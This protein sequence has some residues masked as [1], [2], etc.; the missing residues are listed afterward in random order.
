M[1]DISEKKSELDEYGVWVKKPPVD[2]Q[3]NAAPA[4]DPV[5]DASFIEQAAASDMELEQ[6]LA[7][8]DIDSLADFNIPAEDTAIMDETSVDEPNAE[9][10]VTEESE[11]TSE[12][13]SETLQTETI[14]VE[15]PEQEEE[16]SID[17]DE[18]SLDDFALDAID[19]DNGPM[20]FVQ[21]EADTPDIPAEDEIQATEFE[22]KEN[23]PSTEEVSFEDGEIDLD[24]FMSDDS[25]QSTDSTPDGEV[26]LSSF[27]DDSSAPSQDGEVD[28]SAFMDDSG[29]SPDFGNGDIDLEAFM[30]SEGFATDKQE[31]E[32]IEDADPLD[33]DLDFE[34]TD[35]E[36]Q[37]AEANGD[38]SAIDTISSFSGMDETTD[39]DDFD[40]LFDD[41]VDETPAAPEIPEVT[42]RT[43]TPVEG[44]EE[45]NLSDFGFDDNSDNQNPIL[46]DGKPEPKKQG[47][48]DYEMNVEDDDSN[49]TDSSSAVSMNQ[50]DEDDSDDFN[51]DITQDEEKAIQKEQATDL[52]SPD[53]SFDIDSI[54]DNIEDETGGK[55]S[56][57]E[58]TPETSEAKAEAE[59]VTESEPMFPESQEPD[60]GENIE[61][62]DFGIDE[63]TN[64]AESFLEETVIGDTLLEEPSIEEDSI[65]TPS[66]FEE[67]VIEEVSIG[68]GVFEE[69]P[70]DE[71][72]SP[73]ES[74]ESSSI[75]AIVE[76][77]FNGEPSVQ[78]EPNDDTVFEEPIIDDIAIDESVF[79]EPVIETSDADTS[80][81]TVE[82][83]AESEETSFEEPVIEESVIEEEI[84]DVFEEPLIEETEIEESEIDV[85]VFEENE[86]ASQENGSTEDI[87]LDDFVTESPVE[88]ESAK[89]QTVNNSEDSVSVDN[90]ENLEYN[91]EDAS[92][93][94][95]SLDD[96]MGEEGFT[97]GGPGVTGPYNEDGTLIVR[98]NASPSEPSEEEVLEEVTETIQEETSEESV[99]ETENEAVEETENFEDFKAEESPDTETMESEPMIEEETNEPDYSNISAFAD[100]KPEYDMTGVTLTLDDFENIKEYP[101]PV[102]ETEA[103]VEEAAETEAVGITATEAEDIQ[104]EQ[105]TYSVFIKTESSSGHAEVAGPVSEENEIQTDETEVDNQSASPEDNMETF[106]SSSVLSEISRE[107]ASLRTEI[108]DLKSEFE[109]IKRNGVQTDTDESLPLE[110]S[111]SEPVAGE[112]D[113]ID[114]PEAS[115]DTGFFNDTDDDDTIAL[116]G[117]ELSNILSTAEFT[118]QN[119]EALDDGLKMD[120]DNKDLEE[121]VFEEK[122]SE[123][124]EEDEISVPTVDDVLVESSSTDL[125]DNIISTTEEENDDDGDAVLTEEDIPSP[126]L[127]SLDLSDELNDEALTEDNIEYLKTD[128]VEEEEDE[129]LETG[130]SEQPVEEVFDNWEAK[131][132][133][134]DENP[135]EEASFEEPTIDDS[136]IEEPVIEEPVI[137][138]TSVDVPEVEEKASETKSN[139][140]PADMKEEIKAVLSY[141]DQLLENLPEDKI[142]EFAQSEQFETYKKLFTELGL[143]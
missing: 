110:D 91:E 32:E 129:N 140:I 105:E 90:S 22:T 97:D 117:D 109:E 80:D 120:F 87:T 69:Q 113:S 104:E 70:A 44:T 2:N 31:Q 102:S 76:D 37:D 143:S 84:S 67:P 138:E 43:E 73:T 6:D 3:E 63:T 132:E 23:Q 89:E 12:E 42:H 51:I 121:P 50:N 106:D 59:E 72:S 141:M 107:L 28:L 9:T 49:E 48:V 10:I 124:T 60:F 15:E 127:E 103:P 134:S 86:N 79:E 5:V 27:M 74:E 137:E 135:E 77:P 24:A 41:I 45:I 38:V 92:D 100:K 88:E 65:E 36:L 116:S 14:P 126:T 130:I 139:D 19:T 81:E 119:G 68:D 85:P 47:P 114:I 78:D 142:A 30:G 11:A 40:A 99:D 57:T 13:I 26:D 112:E 21:D 35:V 98:E 133:F 8:F 96:F 55:V 128:A 62:S 16:T 118:S 71:E 94:E 136:V 20:T 66:V 82:E 56:F 39:V 53:D 115:E 4:E 75:E 93:E 33:I 101:D 29:D 17:S 18:L 64:R 61:A 111:V 108:K 58:E 131:P 54:F 83:T 123:E 52:S 34:T 7:D 122:L 95:I 1:S 125:M 25:S 46:G